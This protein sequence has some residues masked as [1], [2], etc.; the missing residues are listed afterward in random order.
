VTGPAYGTHWA[1][2]LTLR[3]EVR[4]TDG[5]VGELQMS[6]AKAVYQT[7]PVPYAKCAYYTE[8]TQP[9]PLL[10]RVSEVE[11]TR[12]DRVAGVS[13]IDKWRGLR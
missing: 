7:V 6:L 1:D 4:L 3:D 9:T 2:V 11:E 10:G 5:S 12:A 13:V 8:I